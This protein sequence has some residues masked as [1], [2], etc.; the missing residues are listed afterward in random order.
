MERL[1]LHRTSDKHDLLLSHP[2]RLVAFLP[3]ALSV[4][5]LRDGNPG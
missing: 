2:F 4:E 1:L 3:I 5:L